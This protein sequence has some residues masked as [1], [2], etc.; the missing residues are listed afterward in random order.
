MALNPRCRMLIQQIVEGFRGKSSNPEIDKAQLV[1]DMT[2]SLVDIADRPSLR[3]S[4]GSMIRN[5]FLSAPSTTF[6][7]FMGNL[8]RVLSAPLD[9]FAAGLS[10]TFAP[11]LNYTWLFHH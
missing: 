3:E 11:G 8:A 9:R 2:K 6:K 7:N 4:A 10:T 5:N 1:A